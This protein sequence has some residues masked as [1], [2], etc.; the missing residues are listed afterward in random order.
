MNAE[1]LGRFTLRIER[2]AVV[3]IDPGL[4]HGS[5]HTGGHAQGAGQKEWPAWRRA[6]LRVGEH[7]SQH[8]PRSPMYERVRELSMTK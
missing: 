3:A 6:L 2:A 8:D 1:P 5:A 7:S 4:H